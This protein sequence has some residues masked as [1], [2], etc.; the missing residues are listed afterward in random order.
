MPSRRPLK[1]W[2]ILVVAITGAGPALSQ[3]YRLDELVDRAREHN[4]EIAEAESKV[5][6]ARSQVSRARA[7]RLLPRLRLEAFSG[8][9][10]DAEGDIFHPPSDTTGLRRLGPFARAQLEFIQPIYTF[11]QL[12]NLQTA[13]VA[14]VEVERARLGDH[15]LDITLQVKELYYGIL[16]GQDLADLVQRLRDELDEWGAE[17]DEDDPDI[18]LS[19]TYK[20]RLALLELGDRGREQEDGLELA[21]AAM[22]WKTGLPESPPIHVKRAW[23]RPENMAIPPMDSLF[24]LALRSRPDWR[25][26]QSGLQARE[27]LE[28]AARSAYYPQVFL[29]GGVRYAVAPNRTDQ[30]NPFVKDEYNYF[31]GAVFL[32]VRQ[33]FEWGLLGADLQKARADVLELRAKE[34]SAAQGIRVDVRRAHGDLLRAELELASSHEARRLGR[35][36]LQIAREGYELDPGGIRELVSAFEAFVTVEQGY[37]QALHGYNV[38]LARLE[39]V[40]GRDL[41][42]VEAPR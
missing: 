18:P 42:R 7:A 1:L 12:S 10:P 29:A 32:G 22:A 19:G 38:R 16:L 31:N 28:R 24:A 6:G 17:L 14:G 9:T 36:W 30:H 8:L 39:S 23:H 20:L 25:Q 40:I 34:R 3:E 21:R 27:A 26:L 37:H 13:A 11:G 4:T 41:V 33:S 35:E 2:P 5:E 15:R